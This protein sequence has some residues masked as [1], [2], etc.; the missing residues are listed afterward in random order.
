MREDPGGQPDESGF[1]GRAPRCVLGRGGREAELQGGH[2]HPDPARTFGTG[3]RM[4]VMRA[5]VLD[6]PGDPL[7]VAEVPVPEPGPERSE[8]HTS[9]LQSRQ[10]LVCRLLLEKKK[11]IQMSYKPHVLM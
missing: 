6:S 2:P 1:P 3:G 5:M 9:E 8:E 7:R 11:N 10:Y 4:R